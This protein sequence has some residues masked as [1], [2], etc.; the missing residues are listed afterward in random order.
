M[1]FAGRIERMLPVRSGVSQ[2][3]E[4]IALP[5]VF[6]YFENENDQWSE[7]ILVETLDR[8][9]IK[10]LSAFMEK[11]GNGKAIIENGSI[12]MTGAVNV[13]CD[14]RHGVREYNGKVYNRITLKSIAIL[15]DGQEKQ[16]EKNVAQQPETKPEVKQQP[17]GTSD[18]L[19]F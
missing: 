7:R 4:W 18:D 6:E 8:A 14:F 19:P 17:A 12:K 2:N 3:G 16:E 5:F 11:D 9:T 15:D 10:R 13:K 1:E